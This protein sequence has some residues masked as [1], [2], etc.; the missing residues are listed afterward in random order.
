M[1]PDTIAK[2]KTKTKK[3]LLD[4]IQRL[5]ESVNFLENAALKYQ[6][7]S[8]ML[9]I[10]KK[11]NRD[12]LEYSPVC[13]KIVS[14]EFNL[15]YMSSAGVKALKIDDITPYYEKPYPFDFYPQ[16]FRERMYEN[17]INVKKTGDVITQEAAVIDIEGKELWFHSTLVPVYDNDK[18]LDYIIVVSI[19]VT[20]RKQAENDLRQLNSKLEIKVKS[21]TLELEEANFRLKEL[22]EIDPLTKIAN[23]RMYDQHLSKEVSNAK[24]TKTI[25]SLLMIDIDHFKKYND[26]YGHGAGDTVLKQVAKIIQST[27]PR[28][29]DLAARFGGEEFVVILPSTNAKGAVDVAERIR[30]N[31]QS[32]SIEHSFSDT[33]NILT[34]SIGVA[35]LNK[36]EIT[37]DKILRQADSA[38]YT[39]KNNGRNRITL[40]QDND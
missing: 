29:T 28:S 20:E 3:E 21:R 13:T 36:N 5:H 18:E 19:D 4:E 35:T 11:E 32:V 12:W 24:R 15:I 40:F 22:S 17:L 8:E 16:S 7:T 30:D 31:I 10:A 39:S 33:S 27:L 38:L 25:L 23:R 37:K 34:V 14:P 2:T 6:H 9:Q 26:N 1:L